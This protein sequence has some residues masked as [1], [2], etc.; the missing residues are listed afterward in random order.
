MKFTFITLFESLVKPY[1]TDSILGRA[2]KNGLFELEFVNPRDFATNSYKKV[3]DY[4][5]SGGAGLLMQAA[6]LFAALSSVQNK[7]FE[8]LKKT[9]SQQSAGKSGF[10]KSNLE[11]NNENLSFENLNLMHNAENSSFEIQNLAKSAENSSENLLNLSKS[12]ENSAFKKSN[13]AKNTKNSS[14][15]L[16]NL[17]KSPKNSHENSLNSQQNTINSLNSPHFIFLSPAGKPF[18]QNDAKRLAK[19]SHL[20]FVCGRYEGIDE[21]VVEAFADEIFSVGDFILTGGELAGLALCD[22]I[23]RNLHGVLGNEASLNEES[24]ENSLLEAPAFTKPFEFWAFETDSGLQI[25]ENEAQKEFRLNLNKNFALQNDKI[26]AEK[27]E[28]PKTT[29]QYDK[30]SANLSTHFT[31][32]SNA[33]SKQNSKNSSLNLAQNSS[34]NFTQNLNKNSTQISLNLSPNSTQI[35]PNLSPNA[36]Q[37][38]SINLTQN[39]SPNPVNL[40]FH[41]DKSP[42]NDEVSA[43]LNL[44]AHLKQ[45]LNPNSSTNSHSNLKQNSPKKQKIKNFRAIFEFLNGNHAII[46]DLKHKLA[47]C[48]TKFF[49]P[50]LALRAKDK[51]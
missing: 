38:L 15:N 37:N 21:R 7:H 11:Q 25:M 27:A 47:L 31:Q 42:Q 41:S 8:A 22:A 20:C 2:Y 1:F 5:I 18:R 44:S 4:A 49:R 40:D 43:N 12:P 6:P 32:N 19:F 10:K 16:L 51:Q 39:L 28:N 33:N 36:T 24:F 30:N 26:L 17:N 34:V 23:A 46:S 29:P 48:K 13:L 50:D 45:N 14:E 9:N 35:S 3:D